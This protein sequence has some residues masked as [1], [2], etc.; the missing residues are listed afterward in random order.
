MQ[1]NSTNILLDQAG[2]GSVGTP[3]DENDRFSEKLAL[4]PQT[5][6]RTLPATFLWRQKRGFCLDPF[7]TAGIGA[8]LSLKAIKYLMNEQNPFTD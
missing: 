5:S 8:M 1:R 6:L 3:K 2:P 7:R 4:N